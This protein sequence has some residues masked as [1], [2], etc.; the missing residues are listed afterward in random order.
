MA[1]LPQTL[2]NP[3]TAFGELQ[4]AELTP[5]IQTTF[6]YNINLSQVS[7]GSNGTGTVTQSD[8][9]AVLQTGATSN[10]SASLQTKKSAKY[11]NGQGG[12][13]RFTTIYNTGS[14]AG[15]LQLMGPGDLN[16]LSDRDGFYFAMSGS[17]FGVMRSQNGTDIFISQSNWNVD[18][19]DGSSGSLNPSK[20]LLRPEFGNVY[21]IQYQWLSFGGIKY[22]I[23]DKETSQF[24]LVH[25]EKYSNA[26]TLPSVY[27]PTFPISMYVTN[28]GNA[29]N[30]KMESP[31]LSYF[32]EGEYRITGPTFATFASE[33]AANDNN[34]LTIMNNDVFPSAS[35]T[36]NRVEVLLESI[37]VSNAGNSAVR[38]TVIRNATINSPTW[39]Y[40]NGESSIVKYDSVGTYAA[41]SGTPLLELVLAKD[42]SNYIPLLDLGIIL[43]PTD[44][45]SFITTGTSTETIVGCTWRE[46]F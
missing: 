46:D 2:K 32:V 24:Q 22:Y 19:M 12:L 7:T 25:V 13:A 39:T 4:V 9:K 18:T 31:S 11:K 30:V 23:E 20:Q 38:I 5:V 3:K 35:S 44:R 14:S 21:Q 27:N 33:S 34:I 15:T 40:V 6:S 26:N 29:E 1:Y 8:S 28:G 36:R 45:L 42:D 41:G 17:S 43:E 37:S 16:S 10:S